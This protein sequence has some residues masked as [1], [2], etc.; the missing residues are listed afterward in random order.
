MVGLWQKLPS[1]LWHGY[2]QSVCLSEKPQCKTI[3]KQTQSCFLGT[4]KLMRCQAIPVPSYFHISLESL[5]IR[6]GNSLYKGNIPCSTRFQDMHW[7][8]ATGFM[9][10]LICPPGNYLVGYCMMQRSRPDVLVFRCSLEPVLGQISLI[11]CNWIAESDRLENKVPN[12]T[13]HSLML[14][15]CS[16]EEKNGLRYNEMPNNNNKK[17]LMLLISKP[18]CSLK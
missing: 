11:L 6:N 8:R 12:T 18:V 13:F 3:L 4:Q 9:N 7:R 15:K 1:V 2:V 14:L 5:I 17:N 10:L 16:L